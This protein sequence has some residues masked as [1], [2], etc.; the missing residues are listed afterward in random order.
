[1]RRAIAILTL[2]ILAL[3]C[4]REAAPTENDTPTYP[5][6]EVNLDLWLD[7]MEVSSR[8]LYSAREA[9]LAATTLKP[10]DVVADIGAGTGLY[11]MLFAD[12]VGENG[13]VFAVDIEALFLDLINQ[14]AEDGGLDN[15]SAVLGRENSITLAHESVDVI[16]IADTYHYFTDRET[17]MTSIRDALKP[18]GRLILIDYDA[19]PGEARPADKSHVR[20]G[21]AGVISEVQS[22][23]FDLAGE[24]TIDGLSEN[25]FVEFVKPQ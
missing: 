12:A 4:S 11:T 25:F 2:S 8:E 15:I 20:F 18:G 16:F 14:R 9:V 24:P 1:M 13:H 19:K 6:Q 5:E 17:I 23:G 21:K 3:A 10:G 7:Q 22:L